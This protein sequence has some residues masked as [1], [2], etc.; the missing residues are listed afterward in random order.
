MTNA[1]LIEALTIGRDCAAE[2]ANSYHNAMKGYRQYQHDAL[3]A[4]VAKIDAVL[5]ALATQPQAPQGAVKPCGCKSDWSNPQRP[6][7][8]IC[9]D[10]LGK[11]YIRAPKTETPKGQT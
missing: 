7:V 6:V 8:T 11:L 9:G 4:D 2:V 1:E 10:C 3:D 5:A